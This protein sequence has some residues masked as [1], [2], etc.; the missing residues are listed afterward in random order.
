LNRLAHVVQELPRTETA[1]VRAEALALLNELKGN[2]AE[3]IAYR[4]REIEL[5]ER[6]HREARS[7]KDS[8]TTRAYMFNG[9]G[10]T[11]LNQRKAL[12]DWLRN[13]EQRPSPAI[14]SA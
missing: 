6:L 10:G 1:I 14:R 9:R 4:R 3:S 2:I 5:M 11:A 13:R 12:L 8:E 7:P